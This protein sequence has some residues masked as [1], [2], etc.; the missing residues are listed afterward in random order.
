MTPYP[1][2]GLVAVRVGCTKKEN[3]PSWCHLPLSNMHI[4][5]GEVA[6]T[7]LIWSHSKENTHT[8]SPHFVVLNTHL[9]RV[10]A[11]LLPANQIT[12]CSGVM[13]CELGVVNTFGLSV[14]SRHAIIKA[15]MNGGGE[16]SPK[17]PPTWIVCAHMEMF[18]TSLGG[19]TFMGQHNSC[20]ASFG[21]ESVEFL[22]LFI[23]DY[24]S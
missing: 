7:L 24:W 16:V 14:E 8:H 17:F 23:Q 10:P 6:V 1:H 19:C 13:A 9:L 21:W 12:W 18:C 5:P 2:L 11:L 22:N 4:S 20:F 3:I 15:Q